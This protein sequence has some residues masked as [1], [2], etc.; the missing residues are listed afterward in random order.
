MK[1]QVTI[2]SGVEVLLNLEDNATISL[3]ATGSSNEGPKRAY[4]LDNYG[5]LTIIGDVI[6]SHGI[7]NHSKATLTIKDSTI[8][9]T[10]SDGGAAINA[11]G[12]NVILDNVV[13]KAKTGSD[14]TDVTEMQSEPTCLK[15]SNKGAVTATNCTIKAEISRAYAVQVYEDC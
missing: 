12:G 5:D 9:A 10:D 2:P 15:I 3:E 13:L 11:Q 1:E 4:A 7:Y 8:V 6:E 14:T